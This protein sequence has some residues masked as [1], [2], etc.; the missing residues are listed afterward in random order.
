MG[1]TY[2]AYDYTFTG[3]DN[4]IMTDDISI[5]LLESN[6]EIIDLK[7][8]L[9]M[10]D[11]DGIQ[12]EGTGNVFDFAVETKAGF[13][14]SL[15]YKLNIEKLEPETGYENLEDNQVKI[16]LTDTE[17]NKIIGPLK[18]SELDNYN[19]YEDVNTHSKENNVQVDKYRIRVW[20]DS[21]VDAS[22]WDENTKLEY[23]FKIGVR[24]SENEGSYIITYSPNG[25]EG[26]MAA[27]IYN[28][29]TQENLRKNTFTKGG[30][31]FKGWSTTNNGEVEYQDN[32]KATNLTQDED[33]KNKTLYAIWNPN[34][35]TIKYNA[36]GG[37]LSDFIT[38]GTYSWKSSNGI[39]ISGNYNINSSTSTMNTR[40]FTLA[41]SQDISFEWAVSSEGASYDYLYYTI[42]KDG[43][44]LSDTGT[45]TKIGGNSS[46]TDES[47]LTYKTVTKTLEEGTYYIEFTYRKDSSG[48]NGLDSGY[49]KNLTIP[50]Y[51]NKKTMDDS[52]L[53]VG[54]NNKLQTNQ[55]IR[56]GYTFK[57]WNTNKNEINI[58][59]QDKN[60][61]TELE[62]KVKENEQ[63]N[64]YAIWEAN[65][66]TVNV[67]VQNGTV[68][69]ATKQIEYN[70]NGIFNL[71]T[72][73]EEAIGSVT[74][75]NNQI[76]KVENNI[77]TVSNVS[78]DTTCTVNFKDTFT[79]LYEDGTLIIN[80]SVKN[81]NTNLSAP[82]NITK[83][84]D[85]MS[86]SNSYVIV[87]SMYQKWKN[88]RELIKSVEIGQ[89]IE[90]VSTAYWFANLSRMEEGDFTNLDTLNVIKMDSMFQNTGQSTT[91]FDIGDL[92]NWDVSKVTNMKYMFDNTGYGANAFSLN[93]SNWDLS[94]VTN[95]D[96]MF[97]YAG[98]S[99]AIWTIGD[100]SNWNVSKVTSM[101]A[102]FSGAG[103]SATTF[104]IGDLS[105]WDLSNVTSMYYMFA[106]AG[107]SATTFDIGD[108]SSWNTTKVTNM[109]YM[110]Q[111][112]G[113][114]AETFDIGN[115]SS[116]DVSKVTGMGTMFR[117]AGYSATT[118][119][120]G[121]LS[122]WNTSSVKDMSA[123]FSG[124]GYS[125]TTFNI[126]NL[127][128][129]DV[130]KVTS[131]SAMFSGAGYSATTFDI[132]DLSNWDLSNVTSMYYMFAYA[133]YSA[134]TFDIGDLSSWNTTKVTNM[135]YMFQDAGQNAETFDIGNLS[136]WDVSKVT[137]MGTMFRSAGYSATTWTV[138]DLSN[139]NTSSVKDMS[140]MF[141]GA[142]YSATTFNIGNLS[143]WNVSNVIYMWSMFDS[144]GN[145]A[146]TFN[147]DLSNWDVSKV[148]S[149]SS[150]FRDAGRDVKS[151]SLDLSSWDVSKVT[152]MQS[153]F[154]GVG[155]NAT[156]LN[157]N[158]SNW[159]TS[160]V[161]DMS[162][163]FSN[164]GF[165]ATTWSV[166]IPN[167]T[168]D[169]TNTTEK[170]Y[171]SSSSKYAAP[172]SGKSFTLS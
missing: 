4:K 90:P 85:A 160:S 1:I 76:G 31:T 130:S 129:W 21:E 116:W 36:N 169:L 95:M 79:T 56:T 82:G 2:S 109:N 162:E 29:D 112:A 137:G 123:M 161:K 5:K 73:V 172:C 167:K 87:D 113:Q 27:S 11:E 25:G 170:W 74:C 128:S 70:K 104:D 67:V 157:L 42:Y 166:K 50:N 61:L 43:T 26:Q 44:A 14:T 164:A 101:S 142:G 134:T 93:L 147:L 111:D 110:F 41:E 122:N 7:T 96:Y 28:K 47:K 54:Q 156:T 105:N 159:D 45:S 153:M 119:T 88:E 16:Y 24:S 114:N 121:D 163:M 124:A 80:E 69:T 20:I 126:G 71:T 58:K 3:N 33:N 149:M 9:P 171:G 138:G 53:T 15:G 125:A 92:S 40:E 127:S 18:I 13:N 23:K 115:L 143:N 150:M 49:V 97:A 141:S 52:T 46:V 102:M 63:V 86:D 65:K 107:Y 98:K 118:W 136:S 117:S 120:V 12:Q 145:K 148:T 154:N 78:A 131:M 6:K 84:Y 135:N 64:L 91:T 35:Y 77:L 32:T 139:W 34:N 168:G 48:H 100:L 81:R 22:N 59:Y 62:K 155:K 17:D 51:N 57:G 39:Y 103:Y 10:S 19:L 83:E 55:Y 89:K 132:G 75:T 158:L 108:L 133:G 140:A 106:Y 37:E 60:D 66:Y 152:N 144:A 72:N 99:A 165:N 94:N 8:S 30:Y 146:T 151:F 68:D 38:D